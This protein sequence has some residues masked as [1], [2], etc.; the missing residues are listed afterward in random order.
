MAKATLLHLLP[1]F[2]DAVSTVQFIH[3]VFHLICHRLFPKTKRKWTSGNNLHCLHNFKMQALFKS[4]CSQGAFLLLKNR[5]AHTLSPQQQRTA[6][7][8]PTASAN[9]TQK[10]QECICT[11]R[12]PS[13]EQ[14]CSSV[15]IMPG[16]CTRKWLISI[17]NAQ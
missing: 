9:E 6:S 2:L 10:G 15:S 12:R 3:S 14:S 4:I 1:S 17:S 7:Q 16:K 8:E 13:S 5:R 11:A